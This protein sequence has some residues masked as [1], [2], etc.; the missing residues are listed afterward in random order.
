MPS[1]PFEKL[2]RETDN[3]A[4]EPPAAPAD[5]AARVVRRAEAQRRRRLAIGSVA[6]AVVLAAGL[7]LPM[8]RGRAR[9][10]VGPVDTAALAAQAAQLRAEADWRSA[11]ARRTRE[12]EA[13]HA[14]LAALRAVAAQPDP[15]QQS[16]SAVEQAAGIIFQQ[17]D[18]LYR[19]FKL[20]Q[21]AAESYREV[22]RL[23]PT[24]LW[25]ARARE[26]LT[27]IETRQG[28]IS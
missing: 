12:L 2:L 24:S 5:L 14:R 8:W 9:V 7:T 18:R 11:V 26:R 27:E 22:L 19:D 1:D 15:V 28:E 6:A 21:Q 3:H 20:P 10:T 16:R 23:F 17:G 4:G 25:A 13:R